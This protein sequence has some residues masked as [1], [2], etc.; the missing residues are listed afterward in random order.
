MSARSY[1]AMMLSAV[2]LVSLGL[3][4][5]LRAADVPTAPVKDEFILAHPSEKA[6]VTIYG[7]AYA[8]VEETRTLV[9]LRRGLN[10]VR[11]TGIAKQYR[12]GSLKAFASK[13]L[14]VVS[15]TYQQAN[16]TPDRLLEQSIDKDVSVTPQAQAGYAPEV[17]GK[18]RSVSGGSLVLEVNKETVIINSFQGVKTATGAADNLSNTASLVLEVIANESG[19]YHLDFSY[20]TNG[21]GYQVEHTLVFG[22]NEERL[23]SMESWV[24]IHNGCGT[25]FKQAKLRLLGADVARG[26]DGGRRAY[27]S[28]PMAGESA[29]MAPGGS[30]QSV[31]V[32]DQSEFIIN[33]PVDLNEGSRQENLR[34]FENI[35]VKR[36][37]YIP[38]HGGSEGL[39]S[40]RIEV[41]N[42]AKNNMGLA[43]PAG[44]TKVYQKSDG[45]RALI[46]S[47]EISDRAEGEKFKVDLAPSK[48]VKF[49]RSA[50]SEVIA[51]SNPELKLQ[52][53]RVLVETTCKVEI[54]NY[55]KD[56][57]VQ[58]TVEVYVPMKQDL[59]KPLTFKSVNQAYAEVAVPKGGNN[60]VTYKVKS[61][62]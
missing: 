58:V 3:S 9:G 37:Y 6:Q 60:S 62:T 41:D 38:A 1:F 17:T 42:C 55:K 13:G 27:K 57:D 2:L 34:K 8:Q 47:G 7:G 29:D 50:A 39:V 22:D 45:H 11:L 35:A 26:G 49:R 46:G 52:N 48:Q 28:S 53:G 43:L 61:I 20:E 24:L 40:M 51:N 12:D 31:N 56:K 14:Q 44:D 10:K 16:L 5:S 19:D 30:A 33:H 59:E 4:G 15:Q 32:G 21:I 36:E 23:D 54:E 18:L 25:S